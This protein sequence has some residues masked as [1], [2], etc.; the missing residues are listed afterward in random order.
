MSKSISP[1]LKEYIRECVKSAVKEEVAAVRKELVEKL[2]FIKRELEE[3]TNSKIK[4]S[5]DKQLQLIARD[6]TKQLD[7]YIKRDVM[8]K[9]NAFSNEM[10]ERTLDGGEVVTE[11]RKRVMSGVNGAQPNNLQIEYGGSIQAQKGSQ[12]EQ[13]R[14]NLQ[15]FQKNLFVFTEND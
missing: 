12:S 9:L 3:E 11:Y 14:Q 15:N 4:N 8:P 13:K 5:S 1:E 7:N 10:R 2:K 6:T